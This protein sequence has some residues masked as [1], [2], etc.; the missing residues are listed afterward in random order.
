VVFQEGLG[1]DP[2]LAWVRL[3]PEEPNSLEIAFKADLTKK[4]GYLWVIWA[5]EGLQDPSR[6][7]YN[8]QFIFDE[9]GSPYPEHRYYPIQ[10]IYQVD[11]TCRSWYGYEPVGDEV[12][13]CQIYEPGQGYRL[14]VRYAIGPTYITVCSDTCA[15]ECPAELPFNYFCEPCT[16]EE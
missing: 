4:T 10:A 15:P 1:D 12:G 9:A 13:I 2:D 8:D 14:C 5:D 3:N 16:I 11:S 7:D 6:A